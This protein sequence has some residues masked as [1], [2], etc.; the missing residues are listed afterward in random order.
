MRELEYPFDE[1]LIIKKKKT[2]KKALLAERSD[3]TSVKIAILG[4]ST[5]NDIRQNLELFLLN[6]G[7]WPCFYES[8]YNRYYEDI[9]FE[10]PALDEFSPDIIY[11]HTS[12]RNIL[13]RPSL[14]DSSFDIDTLLLNTVKKFKT[15][16]DTAREKYHCTIIQNNFELPY[17]RLL[18]NRDASDVHGF[19]NFI[20][21]LNQKFYDYANLH[22][23]FYIHDILTESSLYG[24]EEWANPYYWYMYKYA[25]SV[26]AIPYTCYGLSNIIKSLYGKNKKAIALDFDNTL[27]SGVIG[28]LGAD[29]IEIGMETAVGETYME[30]QKYLQ[31]LQSL[32]VLLTAASKN[33]KEVALS[34][35]NRPD[36]VLKPEDFADMQINW[37]RKDQN[38]LK[39]AERLHLLPDSFVFAD[40][41]PAEREIVRKGLRGIAVPELT[42]P[43][44]YIKMIDRNGYFEVTRLSEDDLKRKQMYAENIKREIEKSTYVD[45]GEY[46]KDLLMKAEID[47][48]VPKYLNRIAQLTNKSNQFNLTTKR[49]SL[50]EIE[51]ATEDEK[52]LTLYGKLEDKFGDNGVVSVLIGTKKG[53][54]LHMD[55]WLMSCRV[56]KRDMEYAM[57]DTL[58]RKCK[59]QGIKTIIGYYYPTIKNE[60]V[61]DFYSKMGFRKIREDESHN[62]TWEFSLNDPYTEKCEVIKIA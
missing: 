17:F 18:G 2:L 7:I 10:N 23:D 45:Y 52:K 35:L 13:E 24:L 16:W 36:S 4:G 54:A 28:D 11:I 32:G 34:G 41:N 55:L 14:K 1:E 48:F 49:Y 15:I 33:D 21:R 3:F 44:E 26:P 12:N 8:E 46:L 50:K 29:G 30:F 59:E 60:M 40:D 53:T 20:T 58:V 5:T 6:N 38:I 47:S 31:G 25:L 51:D 37:E 22:E 9:V 43:E 57:M 56:L 39:T 62:T 19:T 61:K 42:T 27:W